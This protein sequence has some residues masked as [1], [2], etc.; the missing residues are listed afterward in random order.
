[1]GAE[2]LIRNYGYIAVLAGTFFEGETILLI[3]GFFAH[4]G[5]LELPYV[6]AAAFA[7]TLA[8]DQLFF[9]AGRYKGMKL[10]E[11]R[12]AWRSKSD[13]VFKLLHRHQAVLILGFRFIYGLRTVT[14]LVIGSSGISPIR[15][16]IL[17]S[18]GAL[19]WAVI[20]GVLGYYFGQTLELLIGDIKKYELW[21]VAAL[22][23]V[24]V[25]VWIVY[26][27]REKRRENL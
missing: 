18:C 19:L 7:G 11:K 14:P 9:Y 27:R 3:A 26:R 6:I 22:L 15:F 12:P 17:N 24:A 23:L 10:I 2:E 13:R 16:L 25:L 8:S 4:L 21:V 1:M 20:I 5:Y